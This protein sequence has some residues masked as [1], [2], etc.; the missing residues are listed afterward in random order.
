MNPVGCRKHSKAATHPDWYVGG[1][2]VLVV[3]KVGDTM[4]LGEVALW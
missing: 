4:V 2:V 1:R 3:P